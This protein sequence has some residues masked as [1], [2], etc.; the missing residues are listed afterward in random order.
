M[1][2]DHELSEQR[3][4]YHDG[5]KGGAI[6]TTETYYKILKEKW[7]K[8]DKTDRDQIRAY[9]EYK[10]LLRQLIDDDEE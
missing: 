6:M 7:E 4:E 9:N 8:V 1:G 3:M 10:R 5:I 2:T